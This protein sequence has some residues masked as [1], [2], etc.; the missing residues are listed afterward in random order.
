[1]AS[2]DTPDPETL[3]IAGQERPLPRLQCWMADHR[4]SYSYSGLKLTPP[5]LASMRAE[6]QG[7]AEA[8]L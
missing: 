7:E 6:G 5:T 3:T 8:A 1:M 4:R 2:P